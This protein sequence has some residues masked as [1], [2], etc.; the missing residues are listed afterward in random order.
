MATRP[1]P[2]EVT[3]FLKAWSTG[4]KRALDEIIPLVYRQLQHLAHRYMAHERCEH[5]LQTTALINEAYLRLVD[6]GKVN[7]QDR[8]HFFAVAAQLMRRILIDLARCRGYHKRGGGAAHLPLDEALS[9]CTETEPDLVALDDALNALAE[10]DRRKSK[11]VE[12]RFFGGLG[13]EEIAEVLHISSDTVTRDWKF[14]KLWLLR[15]LTPKP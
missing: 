4:D 12:L 3:R 7:W 5:P 14:A 1:S 8:A 11:V 13:I 2:D 9:V 6:C 15:E 10:L